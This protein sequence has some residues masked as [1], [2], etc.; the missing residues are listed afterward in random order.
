MAR[1][2]ERKYE[3]TMYKLLAVFAIS[4]FGALLF[5]TFVGQEIGQS[6][7]YDNLE[8]PDYCYVSN[9]ED[10]VICSEISDLTAD[11]MCE[12]FSTPAKKKLKVLFVN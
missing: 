1:E 4:L 3:I 9:S 12:I 10:K 8:V 6:R 7:A 11:E 2:R 5:G